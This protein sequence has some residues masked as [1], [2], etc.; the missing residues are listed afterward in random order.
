[1]SKWQIKNDKRKNSNSYLHNIYSLEED[2][3]KPLNDYN[4]LNK[5]LKSSFNN[6]SMNYDLNTN[7]NNNYSSNPD[8]QYKFRNRYY[9]NYDSK[10]KIEKRKLHG[11]L[12]EKQNKINKYTQINIETKQRTDNYINEDNENINIINS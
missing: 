5:A 1:M 3:Y 2:N 12:D 6:T 4:N 10:N 9:L 7:R 8:S 11:S